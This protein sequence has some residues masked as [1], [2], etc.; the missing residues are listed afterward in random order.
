MWAADECDFMH[1]GLAL[2]PLCSGNERTS[3]D[4]QGSLGSKAG[5]SGR[6]ETTSDKEATMKRL[7]EIDDLDVEYGWEPVAFRIP[8]EGEYFIGSGGVMHCRNSCVPDG[9]RLILVDAMTDVSRAHVGAIIL[10]ANVLEGPY[11]QRVLVDVTLSRD[12]PFVCEAIDH[13]APDQ[14]W[15]FAKAVKPEVK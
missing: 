8:R 4:D 5:D 2:L 1:R 15:R 13:R 10:V 11:V 7:L 12:Y 14:C 6:Q 9:P 3:K